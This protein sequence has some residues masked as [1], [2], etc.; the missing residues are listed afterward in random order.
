MSKVQLAGNAN[1]TGIFT[2]ASPNSNTDRT[3]TLPDSSG[4][5]LNNSSNANFPA[6]SIVQAVSFTLATSIGTS[7]SSDVDTGLTASITPKSSTNKILVIISTALRATGT[8]GNCYVY[9]KLWRGAIG[10]GTLLLNHY[11]I[12]GSQNTDHR[13]VGTF[14]YLDSPATASSVTYRVSIN[15]GYATSVAINDTTSPSTIT[16]LEVAA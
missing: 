15:S 5:L 6:G 4:T 16:L 9:Q 10:S 12:T 14:T 3:L 1:G 2:I 7:S 8:G 13:G 11:P